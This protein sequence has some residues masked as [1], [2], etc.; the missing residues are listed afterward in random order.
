M[1]IA[2][3]MEEKTA[4]SLGVSKLW[5]AVYT[6]AK[7]F[8]LQFFTTANW[9]TSHPLRETFFGIVNQF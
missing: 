9:L 3:R 5:T 2:T 1:S 6:A 4:N 8:A 7:L